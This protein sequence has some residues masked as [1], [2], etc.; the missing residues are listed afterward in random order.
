PLSP[1]VLRKLDEVKE[2]DLL[3]KIK[4]IAPSHGQIWTDPMKIIGAYSNWATGQCR[5]KVTII[6]DTM[7]GSTQKMAHALAEGIMSE[8]VD[9]KMYFL[10]NDERSE[11]VKDILD[12][13][14]VLFGIP[15]IFNKPFPSI[16]DIIFYL[17]GLRFD[18]TGFKKL[19]L[20][21]GSMGWA[22]GAV[23][24]LSTDLEN[25]GFEIFDTK[26]L[27]YVPNTDEMDELYDLGKKLGAKVKE[28]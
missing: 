9:V 15:T 18:R 7:H 10:H 26:Q 27:T 24:K 20:I 4:M 16:G 6:Y 5:D 21:F 19:T 3:D 22:G 2:L 11:I 28:I 17:D 23:K 8:D 1:L 13:K 14:A 12:S 25:M